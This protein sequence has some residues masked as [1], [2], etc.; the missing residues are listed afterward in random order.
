MLCLVYEKFSDPVSLKAWIPNFLLMDMM[1]QLNVKVIEI[2][3]K[4]FIT[5]S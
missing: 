5:S 3:S 1:I 4:G 2:S